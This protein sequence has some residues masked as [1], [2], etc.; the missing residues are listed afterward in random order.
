MP[1]RGGRRW[2][3]LCRFLI[4]ILIVGW[5]LGAQCAALAGDLSDRLAD[6]PHWQHPPKGAVAKGELL[7]PEWFEGTWTA[8]STLK[9]AVA[10]FAPD[11]VTPGFQQNQ[12]SI[13]EATVFTVKFTN[14]PMPIPVKGTRGITGIELPPP[15]SAIVADRVFNSWSLGNA[16]LGE[17]FVQ[18]VSLDPNDFNRLI[19]QFKDGQQLISESRERAI[20]RNQPDQFISSEL[21]L[22]T[23]RTSSQIYLNQVE[24]TTEYRCV[25]PNRIE[26]N[27]I[28]AIYLSPKDP[29][30]FK[31]KTRPVALYRYELILDH[32]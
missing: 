17:G 13:N 10:P 8:T 7:Y 1:N 6:F 28:T 16:T 27:Q 29:D 26:A 21:F 30:Y 31:A 18:S 4:A 9:E 3:P 22:Q 5:S 11:L 32:Q 23:F 20:E 25:N 14:D 15:Q 19:T 2:G 24:N 12:A